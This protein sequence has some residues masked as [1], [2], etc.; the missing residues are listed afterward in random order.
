MFLGLNGTGQRD[1]QQFQILGAFSV[2][3]FHA[4]R[5]DECVS[6]RQIMGRLAL[7]FQGHGAVHHK[8]EEY[9]GAMAGNRWLLSAAHKSSNHDTSN[10]FGSCRDARIAGFKASQSPR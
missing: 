5:N 9:V 6:R 8:G 2:G 7:A 4:G 1:L 10:P 3:G